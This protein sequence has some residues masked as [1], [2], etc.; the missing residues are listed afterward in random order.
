MGAAFK[1]FLK[2]KDKRGYW[3]VVTPIIVV[4][5]IP[6]LMVLLLFAAI[7][8]TTVSGG[9]ANDCSGSGGS[10]NAMPAATGQ[11]VWPL[12]Q[13]TYTL[14]SGFGPRGSEFH[15]GQDLAAALDT[16]IYAALDGTVVAAG[17]ASGFGDWVVLDSNLAGKPVSTV[18]GHMYPNGIKVKTGDKVTAGQ[19]IAAVGNNGQSSGPHLHFEVWPGGRLTGGQAIDPIPWLKDAGQPGAPDRKSVV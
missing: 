8:G 6:P 9:A 19:Q 18:Y 13:G 2:L 4:C 7:L 16:P 14:S 1:A 5:L 3:V 10:T 12:K 17:P 11:K 15:R